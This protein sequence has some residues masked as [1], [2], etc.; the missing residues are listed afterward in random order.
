MIATSDGQDP[1]EGQGLD[2]DDVQLATKG[3]GAESCFRTLVEEERD[4]FEHEPLRGDGE[5]SYEEKRLCSGGENR[6]SGDGKMLTG[7]SELAGGCWR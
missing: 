4:P 3:V 6:R 1:L 7:L 2:F 5:L